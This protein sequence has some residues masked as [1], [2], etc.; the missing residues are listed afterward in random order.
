MLTSYANARPC[1]R[2][3]LSRRWRA[4]S[5][6]QT[7]R[8]SA[9]A[10][11]PFPC[12]RLALSRRADCEASPP[13]TAIERRGY[14][15][16]SPVAASLCRGVPI[17]R[18]HPQTRRQSAVAT[19]PSPVAASLCRGVPIARLHPR[20]T[21]TERRGYNPP[22]AVR[23]RPVLFASAVRTGRVSCAQTADPAD[24]KT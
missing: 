11:A 16:L 14:S 10:T 9:V 15:G 24:R 8:Q 20:D 17:A 3:A 2:L 6:S 4:G 7:R 12:S 23:A 1:S 18:L 19:A 22:P 5:R 21:A 13:D